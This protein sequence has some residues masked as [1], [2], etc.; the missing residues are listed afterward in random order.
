MPI[1]L[2]SDWEWERADAA[3]EARLRRDPYGVGRWV[4]V[5][6]VLKDPDKYRRSSIFNGYVGKIVE[7]KYRPWTIGSKK[8]EHRCVLFHRSGVEDESQIVR[9]ELRYLVQVCETI[10]IVA[11]GPSWNDEKQMTLQNHIADIEDYIHWRHTDPEVPEWYLHSLRSTRH[12][13]GKVP[14]DH[15]L[16]PPMLENT[17]TSN[18]IQCVHYSPREGFI[19]LTIRECGRRLQSKSETDALVLLVD[20]VHAILLGGQRATLS[21]FKTYS[22]GDVGARIMY[23]AEAVFCVAHDALPSITVEATQTP[24]AIHQQLKS[25]VAD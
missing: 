24:G 7:A 4:V 6:D 13:N 25:R 8:D 2:V 9:I 19:E 5:R 22:T 10:D 1:D 11:Q 16:V 21:S 17:L 18:Y 3:E 20:T 14:A 12:T 23:R 15:G